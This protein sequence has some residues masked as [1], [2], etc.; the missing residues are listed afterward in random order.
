[1][2]AIVTYLMLITLSILPL[3]ISPGT[4]QSQ[5]EATPLH[6]WHSF[7]GEQQA[8]LEQLIANYNNNAPARP[9]EALAFQNAGA[10]YD[11]IILQLLNMREL[12]DIALIWPH[13]A[14][15]FDLSERV[16]DLSPYLERILGDIGENW[17]ID[18]TTYAHD[19]VTGKIL[20]LPLSLY[21][22]RLFVNRDALQELGYA[23]LPANLEALA[24]AACT[25]REEAGWSRGQFG[26]VYGLDVLL[27]AETFLTLAAS[28]DLSL[29]DGQ[30]FSFDPAA[31]RPLLELM[32]ELETAACWRMLPERASGIDAFA[33]GQSLFLIE[34]SSAAPLIEEAI[35]LNFAAP[36]EWEMLNLPGGGV[37]LYY[38]PIL[39]LFE[40]DTSDTQ[41]AI[42]FLAWMMATEQRTRWVNFIGGAPLEGSDDESVALSLPALAGYDVIRLE[43]QFALGRLVRGEDAIAEGLAALE[44]LSNTIWRNYYGLEETQP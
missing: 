6:L 39:T 29:Y 27:D 32:Q 13:E 35:A 20:G 41:A 24:E 5:N 44:V 17:R 36:F 19:P 11:Q 21:S 4:M 43:V 2:R 23:E 30:N 42:E 33:R 14:A 38:G 22:H 1:M 28:Q 8:E 7:Q 15:T 18:P 9:V 3:F 26:V 10:L 40:Q 16:L 25:F 37:D 12:P 31:L 34:S